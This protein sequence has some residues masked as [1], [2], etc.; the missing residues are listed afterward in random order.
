MFY[1]GV[2]IM[3]V[4]L[5][6]CLVCDG[7]DDES[8]EVYCEMWWNARESVV[9]VERGEDFFFVLFDMFNSVS[10]GVY[11]YEFLILKM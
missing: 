7:G 10:Y 3:V 11:W 4:Y 1:V 5:F 9:E 8:V 6:V 2:G